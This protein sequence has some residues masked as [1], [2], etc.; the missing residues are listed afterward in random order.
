MKELHIV[1]WNINGLKKH[2][3]NKEL[4]EYLLH[5]Q[6]INL[7]ETFAQ[8]TDQFRDILPGYLCISNIRDRPQN[9]PGKHPGGINVFVAKYLQHFIIETITKYRD[10]VIVIWNKLIFG[11]VKDICMCFPYVAPENS[12]IYS[13]NE[14]DGIIL[15]ENIL[16]ELTL[17]YGDLHFFVSGDLNARTSN[18]QDY[19]E[20]DDLELMDFAKWYPKDNFNIKRNCKD[21]VINR[22]GWSLL[23]LML[24]L[25]HPFFKWKV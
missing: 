22:F 4:F 14:D 16:T 1:S 19:I 12:S 8:T 3:E 6:I 2:L 9:L 25:K 7:Q 18:I 5:F 11:T 20:E 15:L 17:K 10:I 13:A 21:S 24:F 23:N